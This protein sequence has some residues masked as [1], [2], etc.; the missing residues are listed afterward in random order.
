MT[1]AGT[2]PSGATTPRVTSP[3]PGWRPG[4]PSPA[5]RRRTRR[6]RTGGWCP[7]HA[8]SCRDSRCAGRSSSRCTRRSSPRWRL[9][10]SRR[11]TCPRSDCCSH[12]LQQHKQ[13]KRKAKRLEIR[14]GARCRKA[15][16]LLSRKLMLASARF[17]FA[18]VEKENEKYYLIDINSGRFRKITVRSFETLF[19]TISENFTDYFYCLNILTVISWGWSLDMVHVCVCRFSICS[20]R[21]HHWCWS[22]CRQTINESLLKMLFR[23][24]H[25]I[26]FLFG[27]SSIWI[28]VR[29][30][31]TLRL[32]LL[33][34]EVVVASRVNIYQNRLPDA[35]ELTRWQCC[36]ILNWCWCVMT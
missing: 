17:V 18:R 26:V 13:R 9:S 11:C 4:W 31:F 30:I 8:T 20:P 22:P 28:S 32:S 36:R 16:V 15:E 24:G 25:H 14:D 19:Y 23:L 29:K 1:C 7:S 10:G 5:P 27:W 2:T 12:N 34:Q 6:G 33:G 35:Q 3:P 21:P